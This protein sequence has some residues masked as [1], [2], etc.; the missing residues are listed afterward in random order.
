[1]GRNRRCLLDLFSSSEYRQ[2]DAAIE[3]S[4]C[5]EQEIVDARP[6]G[7]FPGIVEQE[8]PTRLVGLILTSEQKNRRG[9]LDWSHRRNRKNR[10]ACW[11]YSLSSEMRRTERLLD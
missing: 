11:T 7:P 1:M 2:L 10:R 8:E 6:A 9:P 3:Y 5:S 4:A